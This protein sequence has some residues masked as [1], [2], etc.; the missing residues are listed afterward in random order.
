ML[1]IKVFVN[2]L[3]VSPDEVVVEPLPF[4]IIIWFATLFIVA[5]FPDNAVS[6]PVILEVAKSGICDIVHTLELTSVLI[7]AV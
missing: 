7:L 2:V 6:S 1:V 4:P 5:C 3:N